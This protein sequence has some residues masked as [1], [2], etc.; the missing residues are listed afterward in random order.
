MAPNQ[1]H[2]VSCVLLK[3]GLCTC[4]FD[5]PSVCVAFLQ[6]FCVFV[7]CLFLVKIQY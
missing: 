3:N 4:E 6:C 1:D 2:I 5:V 7:L